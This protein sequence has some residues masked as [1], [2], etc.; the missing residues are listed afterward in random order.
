ML[1]HRWERRTIWCKLPTDHMISGQRVL[2][3]IV[4][5]ASVP[6]TLQAV[7]APDGDPANPAFSQ[8]LGVLPASSGER[9]YLKLDERLADRPFTHLE[10]VGSAANSWMTLESIAF[11]FRPDAADQTLDLLMAE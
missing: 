5:A 9:T 4:Y 3:I 6:L 1:P 11:T 8:V 10:I 2:A 7:G